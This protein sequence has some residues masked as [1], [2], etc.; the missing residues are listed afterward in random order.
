VGCVGVDVNG[1]ILATGRNG[2]ARG[3]LHCNRV[4]YS[5]DGTTLFPHACP[6][7]N[8]PSG[9]SLDDCYAIHAEQNMLSF[10]SDIMKL[11]TVYITASPCMTCVKMLMNTSA[12]RLVFH[13]E[14]S[15][16]AAK[17]KWV[18]GDQR[19]WEQLFLPDHL[20]QAI[21][22]IQCHYPENENARD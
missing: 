7:A 1:R 11:H 9:Q 16:K 5:D 8:A 10:C 4:A 18:K 15:H 19:A 3:E 13:E 21:N 14:Y 17:V 6:G 2:T 22:L 12:V 20:M